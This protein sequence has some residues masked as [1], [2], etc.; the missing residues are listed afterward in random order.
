MI[1]TKHKT[2]LLLLFTTTL[3]SCF[4]WGAD[5]DVNSGSNYE[6]VILKREVFNNSVELLPAKSQD[7]MGKIYIKDHYLFISEPNEGF[8]I[9]DNTDPENPLKLKFLKVMGSTDISI[10]GDVLYINNAVDLI[11]ITFNGNLNELTVTKRIE[12]IFPELISPD[13]FLANLA[14]DEVVIDWKLKN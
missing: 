1:K 6:P 4:Y 3:S 7:V 12:N 10:K 2:L 9:F 11:A 13:G 5:D 14:Q 8:H